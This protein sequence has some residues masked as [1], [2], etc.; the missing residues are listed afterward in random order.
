MGE[1]V[2]AD[3]LVE[4]LGHEGDRRGLH[5]DYAGARDRNLLELGSR[6]RDGV[7]GFVANDTGERAAVAGDDGVG[8][9]AVDD[10]RA[11]IEGGFK[12]VT[13]TADL[14]DA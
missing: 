11:W 13:P 12:Q 6:Q 5:A 7:D 14:P 10:G 9:E 4:T 2:V 1:V 3:V 8:L